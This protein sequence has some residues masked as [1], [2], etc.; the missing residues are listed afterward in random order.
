MSCQ[1]FN[2]LK[3]HLCLYFAMAIVLWKVSDCDFHSSSCLYSVFSIHYITEMMSFLIGLS[4]CSTGRV[5]KSAL[6]ESKR[7]VTDKLVQLEAG[8]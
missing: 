6:Y 7:H 1:E 4:D 8:R 2:L 5:L 3:M